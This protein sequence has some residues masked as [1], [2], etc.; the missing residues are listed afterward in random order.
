MASDWCEHIKLNDDKRYVYKWA[1]ELFG[2]T[3]VVD[4]FNFCPD[5][6]KKRPR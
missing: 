2:N 3:Y 6:G 1:W 4:H 5:C